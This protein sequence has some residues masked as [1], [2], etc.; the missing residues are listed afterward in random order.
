MFSHISKPPGKQR[1]GFTIIE[2]VIIIGLMALASGILSPLYF[3][4]TRSAKISR[5]TKE[6]DVIS[7]ALRS[8]YIDTCDLTGVT[9]DNLNELGYLSA[10]HNDPW[11]NPY[12]LINSY[13]DVNTDG[14]PDANSKVFTYSFGPDGIGNTNTTTGEVFAGNDDIV[15]FTLNIP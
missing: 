14:R 15:V 4:S 7:S 10:I 5:A 11:D 9:L 13:L 12:V 3:S 1:R 6:L 8:Y 2:F